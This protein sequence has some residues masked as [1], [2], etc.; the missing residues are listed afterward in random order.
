MPNRSQFTVRGLLIWTTVL[1]IG[2]VLRKVVVDS[3]AY[4]A[5][6]GVADYVVMLPAWSIFPFGVFG[7]LVAPVAM[8]VMLV[9]M[10]YKDSQSFSNGLFLLITTIC[11]VAFIA[12]DSYISIN[13][14]LQMLS[15][16]TAS[17][18]ACFIEAYFRTRDDHLDITLA[19]NRFLVSSI[20][21]AIVVLATNLVWGTA[22]AMSQI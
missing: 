16:M 20:A 14:C 2:I 22:I 3:E 21:S 5:S 8:I 4:Q 13:L 11:W 18:A 10:T 9:A 17:S 7:L 1:A 19:P 6:S 15:V 12:E